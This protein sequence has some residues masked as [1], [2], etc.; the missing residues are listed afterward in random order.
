MHFQGEVEVIPVVPPDPL[1]PRDTV[2]AYATPL[3]FF[4]AFFQDEGK[5]PQPCLAT[6]KLLDYGRCE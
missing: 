4:G 5:Y 6:F 1:F 2:P 3:A